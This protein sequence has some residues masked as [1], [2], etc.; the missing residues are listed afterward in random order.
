MATTTPETETAMVAVAVS[1]Q[2]QHQ[3][4][5]MCVPSIHVLQRRDTGGGV[6]AFGQRGRYNTKTETKPQSAVVHYKTVVV[7]GAC[8]LRSVRESR[9]EENEL[10][11]PPP[12]E[13]EMSESL[14]IGN[15]LSEGEREDSF[16]SHSKAWRHAAASSSSLSPHQ[17]V[18]RP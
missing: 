15:S 2:P 4:P 10:C 12:Q 18:N 1:G 3:Q 7:V 11:S 16:S 6:C 13:A 9:P 14:T 5:P 8:L 17:I